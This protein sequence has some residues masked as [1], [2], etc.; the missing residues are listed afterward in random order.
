MAKVNERDKYRYGVCTNRDK[1]GKPCPKCESKEVQKIRK[2]QDFVCEECKE[3]IRQV[4]PPR[5]STS[6]GK[7]GIIVVALG[8]VG[9]AAAY[10]LW[11][12]SGTEYPEPLPGPTISGETSVT[13]ED[14]VTLP[15]ETPPPPTGG[16][17]S[18][19]GG[20]KSPTGGENGY[21]S[22]N[23]D[24]AVYTGDIANGTPHG[25]GTLEFKKKHKIIDGKDYIASPGEVVKGSFRNGKINLAT[26]YQ[27][28]GN[29]VVI[30]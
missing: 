19:T 18:S 26:W 8:I 28:D 29:Q 15:E 20:E 13:S 22:L 7:I 1:D 24:Y 10:F 30:K 16:E 6:W 12:K 14:E 5:Q 23:L 25:N 2:E 27:K 4:P 3:A 9:G 17:D 11:S 21:G